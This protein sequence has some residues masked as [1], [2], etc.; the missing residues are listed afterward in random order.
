MEGLDGRETARLP[1]KAWV[2]LE[3]AD[4]SAKAKRRGTRGRGRRINYTKKTVFQPTVQALPICTQE[5]TSTE[6]GRNHLDKKIGKGGLVLVNRKPALSSAGS[7]ANTAD[8]RE[9]AS[10]ENGQ[11]VRAG[12]S[13]GTENPWSQRSQSH[14]KPAVPETQTDL[15]KS[16]PPVITDS[17]AYISDDDPASVAEPAS[18][19]AT[20][21]AE[22]THKAGKRMSLPVSAAISKA[23]LPEPA[24]APRQKS[25]SGAT[26]TNEVWGNKGK[27]AASTNL[28]AATAAAAAEPSKSRWWKASLSGGSRR[29]ESPPQPAVRK[30]PTAAIPHRAGGAAK[31]DGGKSRSGDGAGG[32]GLRNGRRDPAP[33]PTVVP[34]LVLAR[35][36]I[37]STERKPLSGLAAK[38]A[39]SRDSAVVVT[40]STTAD[41]T[42]KADNAAETE[43]IGK[44]DPS[45]PT[46]AGQQ[47]LPDTAD[48]SRV[49]S[50][51]LAKPVAN[52]SLADKPAADTGIAPKKH[53]E[54]WRSTAPGAEIPA[55]IQRP[56][57]QQNERQQ[58]ERRERS[59][60]ATSSTAAISANWRDKSNRLQSTKAEEP[61]VPAASSAASAQPW[62]STAAEQQ[63][64]SRGA[65]ARHDLHSDR[66][67]YYGSVTQF[68]NLLQLSS[69]SSRSTA[70]SAPFS[71]QISQPSVSSHTAPYSQASSSS[72]V[73]QSQPSPPLLPPSVLADI[74]ADGEPTRRQPGASQSLASNSAIASSIPVAVV[75]DVHARARRI[76]SVI[77]IGAQHEEDGD[78]LG[79]GS[80]VRSSSSL[81][82]S[83]ASGAGLNGS[84]SQSSDF[85]DQGLFLWQRQPKASESDSASTYPSSHVQRSAAGTDNL[86]PHRSSQSL[87]AGGV[88]R[89]LFGA[90]PTSALYTFSTDA[91][92]TD[93]AAVSSDSGSRAVQPPIRSRPAS[94]GEVDVSSRP[95]HSA[96]R[97]PR[98]IGTRSTPASNHA[99][100]AQA[101][102]AAGHVSGH[103]AAESQPWKLHYSPVQ[104]PQ[105]LPQ[106][107]S[108]PS[109]Q[110]SH[111][112]DPV[113]S[114]SAANYNS[115]IAS[116][117][118][119]GAHQM[120]PYMFPMAHM[121]DPGAV[122]QPVMFQPMQQQ[123]QQQQEGFGDMAMRPQA[124]PNW[125]SSVHTY[126]YSAN[127]MPPAHLQQHQ[128]QQYM[129]YY[130]APAPLSHGGQL[131]M[132]MVPMYMNP[133][134]AQTGQPLAHANMQPAYNNMPNE[135]WTG[136][137]Q[138]VYSEYPHAASLPPPPQQQQQSQSLADAAG[139]FES[140]QTATEAVQA[141]TKDISDV[142]CSQ[143]QPADM[144][145]QTRNPHRNGRSR[146]QRLRNGNNKQDDTPIAL[147][148][149]QAA[150]ASNAG[151]NKRNSRVDKGRKT[152]RGAANEVPDKPPARRNRGAHRKAGNR[153]RASTAPLA[154]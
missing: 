137:G 23:P 118:L 52:L 116:A 84:A 94:R 107:Y 150:A 2:D 145:V 39:R 102:S 120:G 135:H 62:F 10:V 82:Q 56:G 34:P 57:R 125:P 80:R 133:V 51:E 18:P 26:A 61:T 106:V 11:V 96:H 89:L 114:N 112:R 113:T 16:A 59:R 100:S 121:V 138:P 53:T 45:E 141:N 63:A 8:A 95:M 88:N 15:P 49:D 71:S 127:H 131:Q 132:T 4:A 143:Q 5:R 91:L 20:A 139:A 90:Q 72:A 25:S 122:S 148:S 27:T 76:S 9:K 68:S 44:N 14:A 42:A 136:V 109:Q 30:S 17:E 38:S 110:Q 40:S 47:D 48:V 54:S 97:A 128:Q 111:V 126:A 29:V 6:P 101:P 13:A 70:V 99:N 21:C 104:P 103:V 149:A 73:Q 1:P 86:W 33:I 123:Q 152:N 35:A 92:W 12:G 65:S 144:P 105:L 142:S 55:A 124:M 60:A 77:G 134:N 67:M 19:E 43:G 46:V 130:S 79:Y 66:D 3:T 83:A 81:F 78:K 85:I 41:V 147:E 22:H 129:Q 32:R 31:S 140:R 7:S 36:S 108:I 37:Q 75:D 24:P 74:F 28:A 154:E 117:P 119:N 151:S 146:E 98:P 87:Y 58:N 64:V 50:A 93:S 69:A 153:K 115:Y